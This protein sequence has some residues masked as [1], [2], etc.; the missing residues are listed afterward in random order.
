VSSEP[1]RLSVDAIIGQIAEGLQ[2]FSAF[3]S[4]EVVDVTESTVKIKIYVQKDLYVQLYSNLSKVKLNLTLIHGNK[5]IYG[6]DSEGGIRHIHPFE[7]PD[8]HTVTEGVAAI[9]PF[10]AQVQLYL[11]RKGLI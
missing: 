8:E 11:E 3:D 9:V 2:L 1:I 7:N 10:L 4:Y 6:E 5:R